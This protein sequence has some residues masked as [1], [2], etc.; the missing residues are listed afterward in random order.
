M[1]RALATGTIIGSALAV[2][3]LYLGL[4]TG[5]WDSGMVTAAVLG[6]AA[7]A[8]L[9]SSSRPF[10]TPENLIAMTTASSMA[11]MPTVM[12]LLG[13]LPALDLMGEG[14]DLWALWVWGVALAAFGIS[15]AHRF[16]RHFLD[17]KRLT[18]P[19]AVAATQFLEATSD[20]SGG[21]SALIRARALFSGAV[22]AG[23]LTYLRDGAWRLIPSS[24]GISLSPMLF[25]VGMLVGI[26]IGAS[27]VLG[28]LI[29]WFVAA[30]LAFSNGWVNASDASSLTTWLSLPGIGLLVG[31]S[32]TTLALE[33]RA[34][35]SAMVQSMR[36]MNTAS[37]RFSRNAAIRVV[38]SASI[39][40]ALSWHLFGI[41]PLT[42]VVVVFASM[43]LI[44]VCVVSAGQTDVLPLGAVGQF[45]QLTLGMTTKLSA[46]AGIAG[47]SI[48][49]G[50]AG[51]AA[52]M[53]YALKVAR[54]FDG[55]EKRVVVAQIWG[56][57]MGASIVV[58]TYH[59]LTAQSALGSAALP[60]PY[61]V[62]WKTLGEFVSSRSFLLPLHSDA[63]I[64]AAAV[65]GILLTLVERTSWHRWVPSPVTLGL[66]FLLPASTSFAIGFGALVVKL[67]ALVRHDEKQIQPSIASGAIIGEG[68]VGALLAL[69]AVWR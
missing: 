27:L 46:G 60:A 58:P 57:L 56:A 51:Q 28:A 19:S 29:A 41:H 6:F 68:L 1:I 24:F 45:T 39:V 4:Q 10:T 9:R 47:A 35:I 55:L 65:C 30:P 2:G 40:V 26:R 64:V 11:V 12:G 62:A 23:V 32:L 34:I 54:S 3:N 67:I 38:I 42:G 49:S 44:D 20:A 59:L 15:L 52:Q 22:G 14:I 16:Q 66:G 5:W 37:R 48:A 7:W 21:Q 53:V 18:F 8:P 61:V 50:A 63:A 13:A 33:S 17:S 36:S 69:S 25:G 43:V 31:G